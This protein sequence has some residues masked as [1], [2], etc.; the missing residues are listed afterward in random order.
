LGTGNPSV[1][2]SWK[3]Q[4]HTSDRQ[5]QMIATQVYPIQIQQ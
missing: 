5:K 3:Q 4:T 2:D 1:L